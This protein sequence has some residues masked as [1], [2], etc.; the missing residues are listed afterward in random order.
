MHAEPEQLTSADDTIIKAKEEPSAGSDQA[1]ED[2]IDG[3][4]GLRLQLSGG[5]LDAQR[6]GAK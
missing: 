1:G 2:H 6:R 4:L 5:A 3:E